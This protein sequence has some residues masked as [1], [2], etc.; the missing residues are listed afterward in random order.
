MGGMLLVEWL[1][2]IG[3]GYPRDRMGLHHAAD[4][5]RVLGVLFEEM[6]FDT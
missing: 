5:R 6:R 1:S 4:I 3:H 2:D